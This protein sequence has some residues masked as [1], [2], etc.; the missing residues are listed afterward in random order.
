[1]METKNI[2]FNRFQLPPQILKE[3]H[4]K[5]LSSGFDPSV[6]SNPHS[7]IYDSPSLITVNLN[8]VLKW[9]LDHPIPRELEKDPCSVPVLLYVPNFSLDHVLFYYDG[10][11][12]SVTLID[13]FLKL[14]GQLISQSKATIISPSFIPKSR[15]KEEEEVIQKISAA[16]HETSFIKLNFSKVGDFWSYAVHHNCNLLVISKVYQYDLSKILFN[17]YNQGVWDENLSFYLSL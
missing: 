10:S 15:Q 3:F 4:S 9:L 2:H 14:F 6:N 7:S 16:T 17:F 12:S 11:S 5:S 8:L 1:M 13:Q